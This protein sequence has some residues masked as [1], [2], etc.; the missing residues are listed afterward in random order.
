[1]MKM[2]LRYVTRV[3]GY[4]GLLLLLGVLFLGNISTTGVALALNAAL[5]LIGM[6]MAYNEGAYSG[7]KACTL[8]ASLEKQMKEGRNIDEKLR[9]QVYNKKIAAWILII[10]SAPFLLISAVNAIV[11]PF[12][13]EIMN[14][15]AVEEG[16]EETTGAFEF[17]YSEEEAEPVSVN[18]VN[19]I[20]RVMFMPFVSVYTLVRGNVLNALFFLFSLPLPA[21]CAYGYL[22][23]P[24]LRDRKLH[25]IAKGKKRKM[26]NLKVNKKPRQQKAEV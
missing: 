10:G 6:L 25:D 7:E 22:M 26:K 8:A 23:G 9:S 14:E 4:Y 24:K 5:I 16:A 3:W 11:A 1:M 18:W 21:A 13:P 17:D 19:V 20:A 2:G 15:P 12:Y